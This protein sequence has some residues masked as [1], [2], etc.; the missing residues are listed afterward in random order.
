VTNALAYYISSIEGKAT[1]KKCD[2]KRY[3]WV[4]NIRH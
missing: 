1:H 2:I 3:V 4:T